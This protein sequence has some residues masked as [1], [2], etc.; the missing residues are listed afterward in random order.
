MG[1]DV[2]FV[3]RPAGSYALLPEGFEREL[4]SAW[5]R[6]SMLGRERLWSQ[7]TTSIFEGSVKSKTL[8]TAEVARFAKEFLSAAHPHRTFFVST[9]ADHT[10]DERED[11]IAHF[12][13]GPGN[14]GK[15]RANLL[16]QT[17][18][19][20]NSVSEKDFSYLYGVFNERF[21]LL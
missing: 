12:L 8:E 18:S 7:P 11:A 3:V 1:R 16:L 9:E 5:Q 15:L 19:K 13:V 21:V 6:D 10:I 14:S 4:L 2:R 20:L 17:I